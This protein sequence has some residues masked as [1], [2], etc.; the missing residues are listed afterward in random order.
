MT[1]SNGDWRSAPTGLLRTFNDA[2]VHRVVGCAC[3]AT[4]YD[5]GRARPTSGS[6]SR[7]RWWCARCAAARCA[8]TCGRSKRRSTMPDLPWPDV[9]DWLTPCGPARLLGSPPVLRL[10]GDLLYLDRYWREEEQVC[11][12][13]AGSAAGVAP[14][15]AAAGH[16]AGCSPPGYEEQRAAAEIALSQGLDGADRRAG[17]RQ[18]DD[19]R[20][21]AGAVRR[22][23]GAVGAAPLRI[24]LAAPTGKAAARLQEAVQLEVDKLDAVDRRR[25]SGLQGDDAAPAAGQPAG[26]VV[27][28][29]APPR[30]PAAARRHRGRRDVDGVADDDGPAAGGGAPGDAAAAGRRSRPAGVG[31][32]RCGAGRSGRRAERAR[33]R[34]GRGAEDVAPVRRVDR[35]AGVGDPRRRRRRGA[36]GAAGGR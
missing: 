20:A 31:R 22:A 12:R 16:R 28:V 7:S 36:R 9:D 32:R 15:D 23:G 5:A 27:A 3:R 34:A 33:G 14:A 6:R 24:A 11:R 29:P 1:P 8:W 18:D 13:R 4:A 21:A 30:Q 19:G 10:H 26:H 25:L 17:H 2:G 35:R